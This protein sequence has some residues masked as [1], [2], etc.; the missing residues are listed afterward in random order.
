VIGITLLNVRW[1]LERE[2]T[3]TFTLPAEHL[4]ADTL[5]PMLAAA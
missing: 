5:Q 3:L 1:T 2:G 4:A